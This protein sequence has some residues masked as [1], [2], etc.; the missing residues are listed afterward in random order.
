MRYSIRHR[1]VPI[2]WTESPDRESLG[3][4]IVALLP[5]FESIRPQVATFWRDNDPEASINDRPEEAPS[6]V[7]ELELVDSYGSFIATQAIALVATGPQTAM[8]SVTF[9]TVAATV[10]A[11]LPTKVRSGDAHAPEV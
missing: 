11:S 2:A 3:A 8:A 1:G 7:G 10:P 5:A 4:I 9:D 6:V